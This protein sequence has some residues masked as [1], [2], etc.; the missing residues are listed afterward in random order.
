MGTVANALNMLYILSSG[1]TY[2]IRELAEKLEVSPKS[3]RVYREALDGAGIYVM[4]KRGKYG[5]YYLPKD[6]QNTL[7]GL[8]LNEEEKMALELVEG[9]MRS[10]RHVEAKHISS[11]LTKLQRTEE[12]KHHLESPPLD[13]STHIVG[14]AR[15]NIDAEKER[16]KLVRIIRAKRERRKVSLLYRPL[17]GTE[18]QR[19]L[20]VYNTYTY[21][22]EI[23]MVAFCELRQE[24]RDFKLRRAHHIEL[25]DEVFE[26]D[27]QFSISDYMKNCIGV[28]KGEAIKLRLKIWEPLAQVVRETVY[29]DN[30][31]IE[32][33]PEEQA[34]L[35]TATMRGRQEIVAWI[36]S[37]GSKVKVIDPAGLREEIA[38]ESRNILA[39]YQEPSA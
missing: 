11:L 21:R 9:E 32:E 31:N 1:R 8:D 20:H 36:L 7:L 10:S 3:V 37:M 5:G 26:M 13:Q 39:S 12:K 25:L 4:E 16:E 29:T 27:E 6:F 38:E 24:I 35:Y 14:G 19:T 2:K 15:P 33:I 30:Q 18:I 28:F 17:S 34:I 23:Y 22:G